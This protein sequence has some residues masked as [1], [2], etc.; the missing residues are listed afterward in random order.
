MNVA[1]KKESKSGGKKKKGGMKG[2]IA[3]LIGTLILIYFLSFGAMLV[4]LG[5]LPTFVAMYVDASKDRSSVKIIGACNAAGIVPPVAKV[6]ASGTS[7][8]NVQ[9]VLLN[10]ET[11]LFMLGGAG[12]GWAL[13][14]VFP[15][16]AHAVLDFIQK[17]NVAALE[18][19]QQQIVDEWGGDV[20]S[21][22]NRA[23]RNTAFK[24]GNKPEED[25][26]KAL[27]AKQKALP[28]P[29]K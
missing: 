23:L 10:A 26:L 16:A 28:S 13:V 12:F 21:T 11:W 17:A 19:K 6:L 14:W 7:A 25:E 27:P 3:G 18:K 1:K 5:L 29:K 20:E 8:S 24:D 2:I 9:A 15:R 22:A 4:L